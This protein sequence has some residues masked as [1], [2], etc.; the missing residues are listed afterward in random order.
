MTRASPR[1]AANRQLETYPP[2]PQK[3]Q[4]SRKLFETDHHEGT[5]MKK[6]LMTAIAAAALVGTTATA[7]DFKKPEAGTI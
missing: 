3:D 7:Q 2:P 6:L 1:R 5:H 4:R